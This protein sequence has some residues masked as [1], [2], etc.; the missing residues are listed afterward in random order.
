MPITMREAYENA[1][2]NVVKQ[3]LEKLLLKYRSEY[4][5]EAIDTRKYDLTFHD[6]YD[7]LPD[8]TQRSWNNNMFNLDVE[9]L[10]DLSPDEI[11]ISQN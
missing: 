2:T 11:Y 10:Q 3:K 1:D 4:S 9:I 5:E 6:S 7:A 8:V